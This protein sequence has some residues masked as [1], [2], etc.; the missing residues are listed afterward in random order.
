M[1]YLS[2]ITQLFNPQTPEQNISQSTT[3]P[4]VDQVPTPPATPHFTQGFTGQAGQDGSVLTM[5]P[6]GTFGASSQVPAAEV[7]KDVQIP[8]TTFISVDAA[9]NKTGRPHIFVEE[10]QTPANL[11]AAKVSQTLAPQIVPAINANLKPAVFSTQ[12][13]PPSLPTI[14]NTVSGQVMDTTGNIV[15]GAILEIRDTEG[16]PVRALRSNKAGHFLIVTALTNGKYNI[17]T[18][19]EGL[20]FDPIEFEATGQIIMPIAIKAK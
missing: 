4:L 6:S 14:V 2:K 17:H 10:T 5:H 20:D 12:A 7:K 3:P 16:R 19:K 9:A 8:Q 13:A 1:T 15:E 18:E 11:D